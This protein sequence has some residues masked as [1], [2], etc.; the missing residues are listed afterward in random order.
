MIGLAAMVVGCGSSRPATAPPSDDVATVA[1]SSAEEDL[2]ARTLAAA[3]EQLVRRCMAA[4]GFTYP[5]AALAPSI[6][7]ADAAPSGAGYGLFAQFAKATP[8]RATPRGAAYRRALMGS[9]RQT[10]TLRLPDGVTVTYRSHGCYARAMGTLYGSARRY[11]WLVGRRNAVR[12][13]AGER[14]ARDPRLAG[15]L[16]GWRRCM[17]ARGLRYP[18][19]DAARQGVY[20]AYLKAANRARVRR[21]EL[22]TA[23]A[24]R[25]C[26]ERTAVYSELAR[27]QH[28]A[29]RRMS[30]AERTEAAAIARSRAAAL[31]Q[32]RRIVSSRSMAR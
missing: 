3:R 32:A 18:S 14:V 29:L 22:T 25:E 17:A 1:F 21:R 8:Q 5:P 20:E 16:T 24:D 19:P 26:A 15:A 6:P 9:R 12:S 7:A 23:T 30:T 13:A 10:G 31:E 11:Q 4:R 28:D 27:A 2:Q